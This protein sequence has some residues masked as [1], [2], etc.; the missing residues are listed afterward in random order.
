MSRRLVRRVA[1]QRS[2]CRSRPLFAIETTL[3]ARLYRSSLWGTA[4][5]RGGRCFVAVPCTSGVSAAC[6]RDTTTQVVRQLETMGVPSPPA[7]R[8]PQRATRRSTSSASGRRSGAA[9]ARRAGPCSPAASCAPTPLRSLSRWVSINPH[10]SPAWTD[11]PVCSIGIY[12]PLAGR[13]IGLWLD[14][15]D[16]PARPFV[17]ILE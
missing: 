7:I 6:E 12:R 15:F 10:L 17:I 4:L 9:P 11:G 16:D 1:H 13:E 2:T 14:S 3:P 5:L 8:A